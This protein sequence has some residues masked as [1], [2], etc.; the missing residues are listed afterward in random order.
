ML[1]VAAFCLTSMMGDSA[2]TWTS[3]LTPETLSAKSIFSTCPSSSWMSSTF[4][5]L[6]PVR[7]AETS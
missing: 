7:V 6:K 4:F 1:T 3:S 2:V 5:V